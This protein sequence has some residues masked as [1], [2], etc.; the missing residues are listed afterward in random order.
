LEKFRTFVKDSEP[1]NVFDPIFE[2]EKKFAVL[3]FSVGSKSRWAGVTILS[4]NL[5]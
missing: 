5:F 2:H 4:S 1:F 3:P